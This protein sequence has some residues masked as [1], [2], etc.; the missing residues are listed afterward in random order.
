MNL[1]KLNRFVIYEYFENT[2]RDLAVQ[3]V[4]L[5]KTNVLVTFRFLLIWPSNNSTPKINVDFLKHI[6]HQRF[7]IILICLHFRHK[8]FAINVWN[9]SRNA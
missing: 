7:I 5:N 1:F 6:C 4:I 3:K 9:N 2:Y 8:I